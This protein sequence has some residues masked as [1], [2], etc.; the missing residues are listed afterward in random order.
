MP[1]CSKTS[2]LTEDERLIMQRHSEIG[3]RIALSA[4]EMVDISDWILKHHEWW[5]GE[6]YP[7]KLRGE[8]IPLECRILAVAD[9]YDAMTSYRP[10][11]R[12]MTHQEAVEEL[13]KFAGIQFD[14]DIVDVFIALNIGNQSDSDNDQLFPSA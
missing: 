10:Y 7:L 12:A 4:P 2:S 9:A 13:I 14:P 1:S 6:G 11:R 5:N 3:H 8:D